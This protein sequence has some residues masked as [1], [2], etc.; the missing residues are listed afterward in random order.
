VVRDRRSVVY[1][2]PDRDQ[3]DELVTRAQRGDT[4]A[5]AEL[6]RVY[7]STVR[8]FVARK[9]CGEPEGVEDV[10]ADVFSAAWR[11]LG[12]YR[13]DAPFPAWLCGIARLE[14]LK[15]QARVRR[16]RENEFPADPQALASIALT[17]KDTADIAI[18]RLEA[19]RVWAAIAALPPSM[20]RVLVLRLGH[21]YSLYELTIATDSTEFAARAALSRGLR[22]VR[23]RLGFFRDAKAEAEAMRRHAA[24]TVA[25][26]ATLSPSYQRHVAH[27]GAWCATHGAVALP[28]SPATLLRYSAAQLE[29]GLAPGTVRHR[30]TAI[31]RHHAAAGLAE[32]PT[33]HPDVRALVT[34]LYRAEHQARQ[35]QLVA[36]AA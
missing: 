9:L 17:C 30:L 15:R 5:F 12:H 20:R 1:P 35:P 26:A 4:E 24:R 33:A 16:V 31:A 6:Y 23:E 18:D 7:L 22:R 3:V 32:T 36:V 25:P 19:A 11:R 29:A 10:V 2:E 21:D 8:G 34:D 14:L 27:F 13:P 28:A